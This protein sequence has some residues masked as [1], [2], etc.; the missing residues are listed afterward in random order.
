MAL[1]HRDFVPSS[2]NEKAVVDGILK[3]MHLVGLLLS[4][5]DPSITH[6]ITEVIQNMEKF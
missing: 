5:L 1:K 4:G 2:L 3:A 6:H